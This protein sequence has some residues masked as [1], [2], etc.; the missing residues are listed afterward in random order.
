MGVLLKLTSLAKLVISKIIKLKF[1]FDAIN[2][3]KCLY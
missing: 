3:N 1:I 2:F